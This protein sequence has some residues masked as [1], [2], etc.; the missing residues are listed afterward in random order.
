MKYEPRFEWFECRG[1]DGTHRVAQ[2]VRAGFLTAGDNPELYF[3]RVAGGEVAVGISGS[4]LRRFEQGRRRLNREEK[5][6]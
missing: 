1:P 4:A 2:F 5:S 3:F 6:T